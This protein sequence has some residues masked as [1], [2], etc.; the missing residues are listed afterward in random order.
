VKIRGGAAATMVPER[1]VAYGDVRLMPGN[2]DKQVKML[3]RE[4]LLTMTDLK[5]EIEDIAKKVSIKFYVFDILHCDGKNLM[6]FSYLERRKILD[7][8]GFKSK[9]LIIIQSLKELEKY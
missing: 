1:C 5:Y 6:N 7:D 9:K 3:I 2:S 8:N 4:K